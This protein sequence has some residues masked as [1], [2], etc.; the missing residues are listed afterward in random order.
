MKI[1][2]RKADRKE[3][4]KKTPKMAADTVS[5]SIEKRG[6]K[7]KGEEWWRDRQPWRS[8]IYNPIQR[9]FGNGK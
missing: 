2:I 4:T 6:G 7:P 8:L 1:I 3:A 9:K 5:D